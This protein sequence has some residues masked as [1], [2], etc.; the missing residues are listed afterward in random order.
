MAADAGG[1]ILVVGGITIAN[2][3]LFNAG[4]FNWKIPIATL[5]GA[6]VFHGAQ[7]AIGEPALMLAYVALV[8]SLV[9]P[10]TKGQKSFAENLAAWT[11]GK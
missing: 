7:S 3:V 4:T 5:I 1:V 9:V 8:G 10:T 2:D 6:L 11:Q